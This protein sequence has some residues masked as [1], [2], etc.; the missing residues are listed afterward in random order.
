M[1][2]LVCSRTPVV[3]RTHGVAGSELAELG[4]FERGLNGRLRNRVD[5]ERQ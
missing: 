3:I 1:A 2:A 5:V 4:I